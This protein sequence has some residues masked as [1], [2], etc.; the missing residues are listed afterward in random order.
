MKL[1]GHSGSVNCV[2][3]YPDGTKLASGSDDK[4]IRLWEVASGRELRVL[5]AH[6]D[7]VKSL[8]FSANGERMVS[9]SDDGTV[10]LWR[11]ADWS[12]M[13]SIRSIK[14]TSAVYVLTPDGYVHFLSPGHDGPPSFPLCRIGDSTFPF[15][16]CRERFE[17]P[18]LLPMVL[19]EDTS[20]REP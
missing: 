19:A 20:Y 18:G 2:A 9:A 4:T 5:Q 8:A 12:P 16:T 11:T 10:V 13:A 17:V 6:A 3:F 15:E 1:E 14:D 7:D